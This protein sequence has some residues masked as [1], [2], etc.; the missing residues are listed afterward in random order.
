MNPIHPLARTSLSRLKHLDPVL[1][2]QRQKTAMI[3]AHSSIN[4]YGGEYAHYPAL[5][6]EDLRAKYI[7]FLQTESRDR[8]GDAAGAP[9]TP[10]NV[11]FTP[12]SGAALELVFRAFLDPARGD[13]ICITSP[14]FQLYAHQAGLL[15]V[16]VVDVRLRGQDFDALDFDGIAAAAARVT[17]LCSPNNPI[18]T[19]LP[20]QAIR[21][22]LARA[23]GIVVVDEAYIEFARQGSAANLVAEFPNLIVTRTF[24]KAW[25]VAG[26]RAGAAIA[27]PMII[28]T[29]SLVQLPFSF[30][31]AARRALGQK[32]ADPASVLKTVALLNSHKGR[33]AASLAQL[34]V[35]RKVFPSDANFLLVEVLDGN[36]VY[37]QLIQ[38]GVLVTHAGWALP[39][40]LR[41]SIGTHADCEKLAASFRQISETLPELKEA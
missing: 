29:L 16:G 20:L 35:V 39:N 38:H 22:V 10:E 3:D 15:D 7:D 34:P 1:R 18:G 37:E 6:E 33:L 31:M 27:D 41:V 30:S 4:P 12:G 28:R 13:Q 19:S 25:G 21:K 24:S 40:A 5:G 23:R 8:D 9:L 2:A 14:A 26:V 32:L 11:L 36:D 17:F